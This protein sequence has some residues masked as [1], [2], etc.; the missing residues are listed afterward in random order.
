MAME[1][2]AASGTRLLEP[3]PLCAM[4]GIAMVKTES[5]INTFCSVRI[6]I[7]PASRIFP[8]VGG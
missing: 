4:A 1:S 7:T 2:P 8:P 6:F 3:V 5:V